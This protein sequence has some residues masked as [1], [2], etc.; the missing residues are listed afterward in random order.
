WKREKWPSLAKSYIRFAEFLATKLP[1]TFL[2]DSQVVQNYYHDRFGQKPVY[3]P[4][5]SEVKKLPPGQTLEKFG[6]QPGRYILF[7]GR[8]VPENY[9]HHLVQAFRELDTDMRC[10]IVGDAPYSEQYIT[11]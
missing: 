8:L 7:V 9:P 1:T 6:L 10:V 3:I 2:T 4:Y 5:G 11:S